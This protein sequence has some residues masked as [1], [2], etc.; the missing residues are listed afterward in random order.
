MTR[1]SRC[2]LACLGLLL[3]LSPGCVGNRQLD[4]RSPTE[5]FVDVVSGIF[6]ESEYERF[7]RV[8]REALEK[9]RAWQSEN[10]N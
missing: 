5:V 1:K 9:R 6:E 2:L 3:A 4:Q 7:N 10:K 8:N